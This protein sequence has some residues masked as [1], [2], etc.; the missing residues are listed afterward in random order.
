MKQ[1]RKV[2]VFVPETHADQVREAIG[3]AGGGEIG[4]YTF[5]SFSAKGQGRFKPVE[6]ANPATGAVGILETVPEERIEI[7]CSPKKVNDVIA[8]IKRSHPYEEIP[9]DIYRIELG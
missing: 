6:G 8:A 1:A 9:I 4:N 5:C 7:T 2:V 3:E